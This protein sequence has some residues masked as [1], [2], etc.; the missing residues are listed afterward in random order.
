M[1]LQPGQLISARYRVVK[2]LGQG[3]Y[4]AVYLVED[5]RLAGRSVALKESFDSSADATQQF[6]LEAELLARL[7]HPSLPRVSDFFTEANTRFLVMD[8]VEGRDLATLI[9]QSIIPP[10]QATQWMIEISEAVAYLHGQTPPIIHRD[11]KPHNIKI[12]PDNHAVLVDFGISKEYNPQKQTARIAK[13]VSTGFSPPE[14]YGGGTNTYSDVYALAA[15]LYCMV[16]QTVPPEALDLVSQQKRLVPPRQLNPQV[17]PALEQV[18]L[19]GMMLNSLA[20]YPTADELANAL[21]ASI[22]NASAPPPQTF[23]QNIAPAPTITPFSAPAGAQAPIVLANGRLRCPNCLWENRAGAKFCQK[24]GT[25]FV[26]VTPQQ[27]LNPGA[28]MSPAVPQTFYQNAAPSPL[29]LSPQMHFEM[30]NAFARRKEYQNAINAFQQAAAGGFENEALY[31][32]WGDALIDLDRE[33]EAVQVLQRGIAKYPRDGDLYA[34]LG[35]AYARLKQSSKAIQSLETALKYNPQPF[36]YLL[37]GLV[38]QEL[39]QNDKAIPH[40]I[41]FLDAQSDSVFGRLTL[42]RCYLN[43]NQLSA[44]QKELER[45]IQ[46]DATNEAAHYSLS[47]LHQRA[48]RYGEAAK[49]ANKLIRLAPQN[50]LGPYALGLALYEQNKFRDALKAFR[51]SMRLD[52]KDADTRFFIGLC[53]VRLNQRADAKRELLEAARLDPNNQPIQDLLAKL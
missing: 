43:S 9:Q 7:A 24:C 10:S 42:A 34:E 3:G 20:R 51:D 5:T 52:P 11:I 48:K 36:A 40:V 14:Q 50:P 19:R 53:L 28:A 49:W 23:H 15:T 1:A 18:I 44:A 38:H 46:L 27:T 6:R 32:N 8:F 37:L 16:T 17:S 29:Q 22:G 41:K 4:G 33:S 25:K 2:I 13:G 12:R 39:G 30:G 47:L 45:V 35:W 31:Y 26:V 21:R